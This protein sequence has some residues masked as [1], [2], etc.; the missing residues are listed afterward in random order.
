MT[1]LSWAS[2]P[3]SANV[4]VST[5]S[6]Y[7]NYAGSPVS[8]AVTSTPQT[9]VS[10]VTAPRA[11]SYSASGAEG[12]VINIWINADPATEPPTLKSY[13]GHN[14]FDWVVSGSIAVATVSGSATITF[15]TATEVTVAQ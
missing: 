14:I 2:L 7:W 1:T 10:A 6:K 3:A 8:V 15:D 12:V 13:P 9:L 11:I 4:S 5:P